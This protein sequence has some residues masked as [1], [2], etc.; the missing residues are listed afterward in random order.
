MLS[1]VAQAILWDDQSN[2]NIFC[3]YSLTPHLD[4]DIGARN[5]E[6]ESGFPNSAVWMSWYWDLELQSQFLGIRLQ[7]EVPSPNTNGWGSVLGEIGRLTRRPN[8]VAFL[9]ALF[10]SMHVP[11]APTLTPS[12][13]PQPSP[14]VHPNGTFAIVSHFQNKADLVL[15]TVQFQHLQYLRPNASKYFQQ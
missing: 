10:L 6:L 9:A 4:V 7:L 15:H 3:K 2:L 5:M 1:S 13:P 8:P 12:S 11:W 14:R